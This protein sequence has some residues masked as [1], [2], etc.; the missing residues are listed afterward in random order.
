M[1]YCQR[2]L[3]DY[4]K[5]S[6][7]ALHEIVL[8]DEVIYSKRKPEDIRKELSD[9]YK[10]MKRSGE[11]FLDDE[12]QTTMNLIAGFS[13]KL[14]A[15]ANS[16]KSLIGNDMI[17]LMASA[18]SVIELNS[19]MGKIVAAP[20]AGAA[21]IIPAVLEYYTRKKA[22]SEEKIVNALLSSAGVGQ[23]IG[24]FANFSGAQGGCQ[25]ET[26]S[27]SAM[28]AGALAYLEGGDVNLILNAASIALLNLM[29]LI[30]DPIGGIVEFPCG[31]RNASGAVNA[32][33]S[34]DMAMAGLNSTVP[35]EEIC[36]AMD[37]TGK[38]LPEALRE[39]GM[40]GVAAT[41]TG[42]QIKKDFFKQIF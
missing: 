38:S 7:K 30:C 12:S 26:G 3:A 37:K 40:G 17:H 21:G 14:E 24:K 41:K 29:G 22:V 23:I 10:V 1:I 5:S 13:K 8:E 6:G 42:V 35:F 32:L 16:G 20:T 18:F 31:F 2:Q 11:H 4:C 25:A 9:M 28:G 36:S 19:S 15:Y 39:T 27:A 34:A 33:I